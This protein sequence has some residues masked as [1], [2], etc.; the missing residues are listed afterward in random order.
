MVRINSENSRVAAI[1][2]SYPAILTFNPRTNPEIP[3]LKPDLKPPPQQKTRPKT[4][5]HPHLSFTPKITQS[6]K[7]RDKNTE[8]LGFPRV[9]DSASGGWGIRT[10]EGLHPTR[11][12]SV[13]HRPLGESSR[14]LDIAQKAASTILHIYRPGEKFWGGDF[15]MGDTL[16]ARRV[17]S[18]RIEPSGQSGSDCNS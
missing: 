10:P 12:P 17:C 18:D 11:F 6:L 14:Y 1:I 4:N 9:S 8:T 5:P 15:A 3:N 2:G 13:R 16:P 7:Y